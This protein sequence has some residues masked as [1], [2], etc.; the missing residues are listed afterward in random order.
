MK[1]NGG[2][3]IEQRDG[4][5]R[6]ECLEAGTVASYLDGRLSASERESAER[7]L[8]GCAECREL[9][10]AA[11]ETKSAL[12][13]EGIEA[14]ELAESAED[15]VDARRRGT[16]SDPIRLVDARPGHVRPGEAHEPRK[17]GFSRRLQLAGGGLLALAATA[18]FVIALDPAWLRALRG[19]AAGSP[20]LR[21]LVSAV[22][23]NRLVEPRLSGGFA[24]GPPPIVLRSGN[25]E[26]SLP[27]EVRIAIAR[28]EKAADADPTAAHLH[29]LGAAQLLD[30]ELDAAIAT[31][32]RAAD[33]RPE[34]ARAW[35]DLAAAYL[36]R[37]GRRPVEGDVFN[38]IAA[39]ERATTADA[40]LAEAWFNLA[41]ARDA[42]GQTPQ[43]QEAWRRAAALEPPSS[44]WHDEAVRRTQTASQPVR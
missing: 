11:F 32:R 27:P 25:A 23:G 40:S 39:A 21:E 4:D 44:G 41:L 8:A 22:G 17:L 31:L 15:E 34:Q 26:G 38:A 10:T 33:A 12:D 7:H 42:A 2:T 9:L 18:L 3:V 5:T 43:A 16:S 1:H 24:W 13:A 6:R 28:I 30:G 37:A 14:E 29:A 36:T 20:E 35:N 19:G